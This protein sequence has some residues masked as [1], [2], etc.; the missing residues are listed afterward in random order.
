MG[1]PMAGFNGNPACFIQGPVPFQ[2]RSD[3]FPHV[4]RGSYGEGD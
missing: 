3:R 4:R 1:E 2:G